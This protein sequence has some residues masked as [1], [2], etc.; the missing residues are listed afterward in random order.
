MD[1]YS[2]D[3][4]GDCTHGT[5]WG[6]A[7]LVSATPYFVTCFPT[8]GKVMPSDIHSVGLFLFRLFLLY[9]ETGIIHNLLFLFPGA[10]IQRRFQ[11]Q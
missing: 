3:K 10:L 9:L 8:T 4:E 11:G 1:E 5:T 2:E 7:K 6:I